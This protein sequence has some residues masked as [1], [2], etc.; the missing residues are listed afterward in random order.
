MWVWVAVAKIEESLALA[1]KNEKEKDD[2][3]WALEYVHAQSLLADVALA[4]RH[5]EI[6][7]AAARRV[8]YQHLLVQLVQRATTEA[9]ARIALQRIDDQNALEAIARDTTCHL[10]DG[11]VGRL[12]NQS[13]L[14]DIAKTDPKEHVRVVAVKHITNEVVLGEFARTD[15][16]EGVRAAAVGGISGEALLVEIVSN[17]KEEFEVRRAAVGRL[18]NESVL[19]EIATS[20]GDSRIRDKAKSKVRDSQLLSF[21]AKHEMDLAAEQANR[22]REEEARRRSDPRFGRCSRC[23]KEDL[24]FS[25]MRYSSDQNG[26]ECTMA[27]GPFCSHCASV[28]GYF[29][30]GILS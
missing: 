9:V 5:G 27:I 29:R 13:L 15:S 24:L 6:S 12:T 26:E 16:R 25:K 22:R 14:E 18:Q 11:A 3:L 10:R 28:G 2:C 4:A 23:G 30:G 20:D 7:C 19:A 21:I 17:K 8:T 1:A